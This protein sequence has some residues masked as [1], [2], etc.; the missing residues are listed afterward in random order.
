MTNMRIARIATFG[1]IALAALHVTTGRAAAQFI[2]PYS[3]YG[4]GGFGGYGY[5]GF[6]PRYGGG[7]FGYPGA[8]GSFWTNGRSLY[9]PPVATGAPIP[10]SFGGSDASYNTSSPGSY[11]P[12]FWNGTLGVAGA[13]RDFPPMAPS[14]YNGPRFAT[15]DVKRRYAQDKANPQAAI[16]RAYRDAGRPNPR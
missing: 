10:G 9:G 3:G 1:I 5:G 11:S 7:Y 6:G 13:S 14:N 2:G 12:Y 16:E 4:Y 15:R 8:F